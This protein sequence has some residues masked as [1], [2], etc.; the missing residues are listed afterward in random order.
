MSARNL[1]A[2]FDPRRIALVGA[3]N[4]AGSLGAVLTRN[5]LGGGFKGPVWPVN[6]HAVEVA[7]VRAY[8][9]VAD[10]PAAPDLAVIAIPA[11]TV[12][13]IVEA[14]GA[15]GCRAAVVIS[16]GFADPVLRQALL[17]ASRP[18][19]LRIVGPNCLGFLSPGQ[20]INASFAHLTPRPG[21]LALVAQSGAVTTAAMDWAE[22][23][24]LGFSHVVTLGDMADVDFGDLL[25]WLSDDPATDAILLYV[26]AI[27]QAQKFMRAGQVAARAKPVVVLKAGRTAAGARAAFSHTGAMAGADLVYDAAL[28]RAGMIR[29]DTLREMFDAVETLTSGVEAAGDRLTIV[30]NGG[31]AGVMAA[32]A[33]A[34]QGG[35]LAELSPGGME[36]LGAVL[37]PAWSRGNPIDIIGDAPPARFKAAVEVALDEPR[38]DAVLALAC[39][40]ALT[41]GDAAAAAVIEAA[42]GKPRPLLTCWL[43][44]P[45]ATAPRARFLAARVPTY[46]TPEEAVSAFM[47]LARR[48]RRLELLEAG[49]DP[50][51]GEPDRATAEAVLAG[52]ALEG[53]DRLTEPEAKTLLKAY[54]VPVLESW[55]AARPDQV[56]P[57][58]GSHPGPFALKILSA[59]IAH[60]T[61]VGGVMLNLPA[62]ELPDA[63]ERMLARVRDKAPKARIDGF[64]VQAM[65]VRP[66]ARELIAGVS[67]DPVFGPVILFGQGGI[68]V[69]VAQDRVLGLPPLNRPLALDMIR[70]TRVSRSLV[71]WRDRGEARLEAIADVLVALARLSLDFPQIAELDI[72]PLSA[73]ERGVLA[74]DARLRLHGEGQAMAAP[75]ACA[76]LPI[77]R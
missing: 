77:R 2:L 66:T 45:A 21:R 22:G 26:E 44:A 31:G 58:V 38:S 12:P 14:L 27:T 1:D 18:H 67:S 75:A 23:R 19:L 73:D 64:I 24:G 65:A 25:D 52:A 20:G 63:A 42:R 36:R 32:D 37:P 69:E 30:T 72:N 16:T 70:R 39:P 54:G 50:S 10:L 6:P 49:A 51:S 62:G 3:S 40:T 48:R 35:V 74:L 28:R 5:M 4:E 57:L 34:A 8:A 53:R 33:L 60:K 13:S 46:E 56:G 43:G 47:H 29:V 11:P 71:A 59:D 9:R 17:D 55:V 7:G 15:R 41:D 68:E 76:D 61:D